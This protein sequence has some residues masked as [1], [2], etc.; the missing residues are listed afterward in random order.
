MK[1]Q[2]EEVSAGSSKSRKINI[3]KLSKAALTGQVKEVE[4]LIEQGDDVNEAGENGW[5]VLHYAVSKGHM[6]VCKLLLPKMSPEA[7]K[8][9]TKNSG[10]AVLHVAAGRGYLEICELLLSNTDKLFSITTKNDQTAFFPAAINGHMEVCK[11]LWKTYIF[12]EDNESCHQK[13]HN[14]VITAIW[15]N[16]YEACKLIT[17]AYPLLFSNIPIFIG[18]AGFCLQNL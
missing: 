9:V 17:D 5:T 6:E 15:Q 16:N 4:A 8:A 11:M 7:I 14:E 18:L 1:R 12:Y 3:T 13:A 2:I 10:S